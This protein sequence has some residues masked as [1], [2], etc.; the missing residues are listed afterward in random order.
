LL[1][2]IYDCLICDFV[3]KNDLWLVVVVFELNLDKEEKFG[4]GFKPVFE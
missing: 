3:V 2:K 4:Y 1:K